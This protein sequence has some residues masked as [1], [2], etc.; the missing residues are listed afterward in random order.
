M[1][2]EIDLLRQKQLDLFDL[3]LRPKVPP[4]NKARTKPL[5]QGKKNISKALRMAVW[6]KYI[7]MSKGEAPCYCCGTHII[8]AFRF[9]CGHVEAESNGGETTLDNLRPICDLCNQSMGT[10]NLE[11]FRKSFQS[12]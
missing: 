6:S 12:R 11:T 3:S 5:L 8:N 2:T 1:P 4:E 10:K 9:Q 7:G